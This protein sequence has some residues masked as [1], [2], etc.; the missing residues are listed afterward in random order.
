MPIT[1]PDPPANG[2][3]IVA[4]A[5]DELHRQGGR[6]DR[7]F[8][9]S[10]RHLSIATPHRAYSTPLTA[11]REGRL[12]SAAQPG[13]WRYLLF[14]DGVARAEAELQVAGDRGPGAIRFAGLH[15]GPFVPATVAAIH[16]A[17]KSDRVRKAD[18]E[19]RFLKIPSAPLAALWLHAASDDLL[20]PLA[21]APAG[22]RTDCP[23]SEAELL[24]LLVAR[25]AAIRKPPGKTLPAES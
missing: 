16:E 12:L 18:Y 5:L 6:L 7:Y 10:H 11:I 4:A 3:K 17:E 20:I 13:N 25:A 9:G 21:P 14:E 22:V 1:H 8:G 2:I 24:K 23:G 15:R 19:L